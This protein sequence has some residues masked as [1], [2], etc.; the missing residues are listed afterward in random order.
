[1]LLVAPI[2]LDDSGVAID[3]AVDSS[4]TT[5]ALIGILCSVVAMH[6]IAVLGGLIFKAWTLCCQHRP[7]DADPQVTSPQHSAVDS[8]LLLSALLCGRFYLSARPFLAV[9]FLHLMTLFDPLLSLH[10]LGL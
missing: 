1:M 5:N 2:R 4:Q 7:P 10:C 8:Q 6:I 3:I 9:L